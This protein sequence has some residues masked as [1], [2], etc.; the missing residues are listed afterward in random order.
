MAV[1][2]QH[3][4]SHAFLPHHDVLGHPF[5][6]LEG[7]ALGGVFLDELGIAGCAPA[8]AG[9]GDAVFGGAARSELTCNG[10]EY[11]D[12]LLPRKRARLAAGLVGCGGQQ[13]GLILPLAAPPQGQAFA[14]DVR[15]RA[16]GCGAAS[17]SGRAAASGVLSQLYHQGVEIDAL[18]RLEVRTRS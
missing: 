2:A 12:G 16:V 4:L 18:V 9:T 1:Q 6:A 13:G 14:G 11:D 17:T 8:A 15:S 3:L 10:G 7:A 5:R